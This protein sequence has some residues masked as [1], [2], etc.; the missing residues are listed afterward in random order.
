[1]SRW[2][3]ALSV[4]ILASTILVLVFSDRIFDYSIK[5]YGRIEIERQEDYVALQQML[6]R[7]DSASACIPR[8]DKGCDVVLYRPNWTGFAEIAEFPCIVSISVVSGNLLEGQADFIYLIENP[9]SSRLWTR[10]SVITV[11]IGLAI[12]LFIFDMWLRA[13]KRIERIERIERTAVRKGKA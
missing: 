10:V 8:K 4:I 7:A 6:A 11:G 3:I 9:M 2:A 12:L 1:M 5:S 13:P